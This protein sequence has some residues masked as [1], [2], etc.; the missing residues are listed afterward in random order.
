MATTFGIRHS[1]M[2][3][4]AGQAG[5]AMCSQTL[6][7]TSPKLL[8][9]ILGVLGPLWTWAPMAI[10]L[11]ID[12][13]TRRKRAARKAA[14]GKYTPAPRDHSTRRA[15]L[16]HAV[17]WLLSADAVRYWKIISTNQFD[18][19]GH[20][21]VYGHALLPLASLTW[22]AALPKLARACNW[23]ALAAGASLILGAFT[24]A[25]VFHTP[26][27]TAVGAAL[28]GL[29][30]LAWAAQ[31]VAR[32]Q[33]LTKRAV[34]RAVI[35]AVCTKLGWWMLVQHATQGAIPTRVFQ[36]MWSSAVFDA[37]IGAVALAAAA[38]APVAG[39]SEAASAEIRELMDSSPA[40]V[41]EL[42]ADSPAATRRRSGLGEDDS[43]RGGGA[44]GDE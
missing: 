43:E 41:I 11:S 17:A 32:T 40:P 34:S 6:S 22:S 30:S 23:A 2:H 33:Y 36:L 7:F 24:T 10:A 14:G 44:T 25:A 28:A 27:E 42:R 20:A 8:G 12:A 1:Y 4:Q 18:P 29:S 15:L 26:A 5:I 13:W 21:F 38:S 19:S 9:R 31:P 3:C 37:A 39:T 35:A 16:T